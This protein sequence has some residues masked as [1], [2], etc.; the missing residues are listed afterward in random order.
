MIRNFFKENKK[1]LLLLFGTWGLFFLFLWPRMFYADDSG[2]IIAGWWIIWADWAMHVGQVNAFAEQSIFYVITH[3]P[4]YSGIPILYPFFINLISGILL[5]ISG[6]FVFSMVAPSLFFSLLFLFSAFVFGKVFIA[7]SKKVL[8]AI[9]IFL[10]HGGFSLLPLLVNDAGSFSHERLLMPYFEQDTFRVQEGYHWKSV[11]LTSFIP[12]RA[13]FPGMACML[14][15]LAFLLFHFRKNFENT[16][17][18]SLF[19]LGLCAGLLPIIHTHSF[20]VLFFICAWLFIWDLKHIK[21][22]IAFAVGTAIIALPF[23]F[24]IHGSGSG[25]F[26][27]L[28]PGWYANESELNEFF[29][30]FWLKNWGIFLPLVVIGYFLKQYAPKKSSALSLKKNKQFFLGVV[31]IFII[32]NLIQF[33]PNIWDNTKVFVWVSFL[34]SFVIAGVLIKMF[35]Q[36]QLWKKFF[37]SLLLFLLVASSVSDISG[38]IFN[39]KNSLPFW[40]KQEQEAAKEFQKIIPPESLVVTAY[41]HTNWVSALTGRQVFLGYRGWIWSYGID[42]TEREK[43]MC[44]VYSGE[45]RSEKI[46]EQYGID[47]VV[48]TN[49]VLQDFAH[50]RDCLPNEKFFQ[51]NFPLVYEHQELSTRV[52]KVGE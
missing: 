36:K 31:V 3:N 32:G 25:G 40:T 29:L 22:W 45:E 4:L 39:S 35:S 23:L 44:Q 50:Q 11:L 8:L 46:I 30:L 20:L 52:Y 47:Y 7:D 5:K 34:F 51:K 6:N 16:S 26:F 17:L 33:Q 41:H 1:A 13:F 2:N 15:I 21:H 9:T 38:A 24:L 10:L 14:L 27:K 49:E 28:L 37:A 19:F 42:H 43:E 18:R 48:F 12:Q